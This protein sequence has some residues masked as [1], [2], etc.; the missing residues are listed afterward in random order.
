MTGLKVLLVESQPGSGLADTTRLLEAGH[1]VV[2]C[3]PDRWGDQPRPHPFVCT[4]VAEGTCPIEDGV[5]VALVVRPQAQPRPTGLEA[6]AQCALRA[7][8]PLVERGLEAYDPY[9]PWVGA[10]VHGD[11]VLACE[12][13][14]DASNDDLRHEIFRRIHPILDDAGLVAHELRF[15]FDTTGGELRVTISG[16]AIAE[17]FE[18]RM[19]VR[20]ADAVRATRRHFSKKNFVYEVAA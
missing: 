5:D 14:I 4:G 8:I 18:Q 2:G 7:G 19:A 12:E 16:P 10:R 17:E 3:F 15:G 9:E 13:A 20:V 6:G 11:V 1:S